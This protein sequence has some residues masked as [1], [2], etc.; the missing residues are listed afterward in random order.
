MNKILKK[1]YIE[2]K[3]FEDGDFRNYADDNW[4]VYQKRDNSMMVNLFYGQYLSKVTCPDCDFISTKLDPFNMLSLPVPWASSYANWTKCEGYILR[5]DTD[6]RNLN[7]IYKAPSQSDGQAVLEYT[8]KNTQI[9]SRSLRGFYIKN[10]RIAGEFENLKGN[11]IEKLMDS[12]CHLFFIEMFKKKSL[13]V[14]E[15]PFNFNTDLVGILYH[16]GTGKD[17][18]SHSLE[19]VVYFPFKEKS[20]KNL[21]ILV[22]SCLRKSVYQNFELRKYYPE[23]EN[24][25][26]KLWKEV[27][28]LFMNEGS[29]KPSDKE[30]PTSGKIS[31]SRAPFII[32]VGEDK[33]LDTSADIPEF[34]GG[35]SGLFVKV[36]VSVVFGER[37]KN[38][39]LKLNTS[40]N[41]SIDRMPEPTKK[42]SGTDIY[43][44]LEL[45]SKD[46]K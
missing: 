10:S 37:L 38:P 33:Y 41:P 29:G 39:E 11:T 18:N 36:T 12:S 25:A 9:D 22:Y 13:N 45:F 30:T 5:Y 40:Q 43:D 31:E 4:K 44:C 3:D 24:D 32:K 21:Y 46:E 28:Q 42:S 34:Q 20:V 35:L 1:P 7:F 19:R 23:L 27:C 2:Y 8:A 6:E 26:E 16:Q 15:V 17:K 14:E